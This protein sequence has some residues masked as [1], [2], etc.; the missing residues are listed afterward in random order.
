MNEK[1]VFDY[2]DEA[3]SLFI[4]LKEAKIKGGVD[5]GDFIID[6]TPEGRIAGLEILNLSSNVPNLPKKTELVNA[7]FEVRHQRD[8][9]TVISFLILKNGQTVS[10]PIP[11]LARIP[12]HR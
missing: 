1:F 11:L 8:S 4:K 2:D 6:F 3:D 10:V 5:I 9:T 12:V 7:Y